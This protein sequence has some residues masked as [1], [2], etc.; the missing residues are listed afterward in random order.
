MKNN[1]SRI[2]NNNNRYKGMIIYILF[3]IKANNADHDYNQSGLC[4]PRNSIYK[5]CLRHL[6]DDFYTVNIYE[7]FE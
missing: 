1:I 6:H 3:I 5:N 7:Y 2:D 4:A